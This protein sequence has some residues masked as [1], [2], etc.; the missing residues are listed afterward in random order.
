MASDII[1]ELIGVTKYFP[2]VIALSQV[3]L[4]VRRGEVHGLVG[5]NGA[6]KSTLIGILNGVHR[7]DDGQLKVNDVPCTIRRPKR[8]SG[9][10]HVV[11][12]S[13]TDAVPGPIRYGKHISGR[14]AQEPVGALSTRRKQLAVLA[15]S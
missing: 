2:G 6:G 8:R 4:Q 1:L 15:N 7:P 14:H 13:G 11:H 5:E 12:P 3:D 9:V 10:G